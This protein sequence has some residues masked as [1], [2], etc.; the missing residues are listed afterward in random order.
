[1]PEN[2]QAKK[3]TGRDPMPDPPLQNPQ[4]ELRPKYQPLVLAQSTQSKRSSLCLE[5]PDQDS[6]DQGQDIS[7]SIIDELM[8]GIDKHHKDRQCQ[9]QGE[10]LY[11][12]LR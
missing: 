8:D 4:I 6:R 11:L 1:M 3:K 7:P 12:Y 5:Q 10:I 9:G 2:P